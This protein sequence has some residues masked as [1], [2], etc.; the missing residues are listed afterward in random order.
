MDDAE[1]KRIVAEARATV[2]RLRD[3]P[4]VRPGEPLVRKDYP[5]EQVKSALEPPPRDALAEWRAYHTARDAER[6]EARADLRRQ[7][8]RV[9]RAAWD[10]LVDARIADALDRYHEELG[11]QV[12]ELRASIRAEIQTAVG[13]LRAEIT[14][15]RAAESYRVVEL[16]NPLIRRTHA[17]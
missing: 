5:L 7:D 4:N 10:A 17:A 9:E 14:V 6:A 11:A 16:P 13:E 2:E 3:F 12:A 15:Q 1:R 8:R